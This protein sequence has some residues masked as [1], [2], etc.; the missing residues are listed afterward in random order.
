M[1]MSRKKEPT[2][3]TK[4]GERRLIGEMLPIREVSQAGAAEKG[5]GTGRINN[6]HRWWATR[7]TNVSRITA[8]AALVRPPL[9]SHENVIHDMYDY[10]KSTD[11]TKPAIRNRVRSRIQKV[12]GDHTPKVL[13][14]FGGSGALPFAAAW[15]GCESHSM[16]YNPVAVFI[17]KCALEYPAKYGKRLIKDVQD[18][19]QAIRQE[20]QESVGEFYPDSEMDDGLTYECYGYRWCRTI[21][22]VCGAIIPLVKSYMLSENSNAC[23]YPKIDGQAVS[24]DVVGGPY[25]PI[26]DG[27]YPKKGSIGGNVVKCPACGHTYTNLEMLTMFNN[28]KDGEQMLVAVYTHPK[29]RGRFYAKVDAGDRALYDRCAAELEKLREEFRTEYGIDPVPSDIIPTPDGREY[30]P[31]GP[32]WHV[33]EVVAHGYTRWEH[34]FNMRQLTCLVSMLGILRRAEERLISQHGEEYGC[35]IMSYMAL[36]LNRAV[37]RYCRLA[38]WRADSGRIVDCFASQSLKPT[39]D[40][41]EAVPHHIWQQSME[42]VLDGVV[43]AL[44]AADDSTYVVQRASATSLP[45]ENEHFDAV[46]TDPPYYDSMHYSKSSDFFYVWLRRTVGHMP[47]YKGLFRGVASPDK[48]EAVQTTGDVRN[49]DRTSSLLRD[50][51]GYQDLMTKS[52]REMYR[53]LKYDGVLTLVYAHKS[54]DG[55]ETLIQAMLDA[56]FT[57]TA[58]WPIDTESRGRINAHDT[59][60]LASSIYMVGRKWQKKPKAY[61]RDVLD[62]LRS[63]VCGRLDQFMEAGVSGADFYIAAIGVSCEVYG[64]YESVVRDDGSG[65][66][67]IS[68]MLADIRGICSDHIVKTLTTGPAGDIDAMSKLYISWRWAYGDRPVHY[69]VARKLFTGVGLNI[70][71][72]TGTILKKSKQDMTMLDHLRREKDIR[73]KNTIDVL[74]RALQLWRDQKSDEVDE[75]LI[76]TGN[77]NNPRFSQTMQAI[78]EAGAAKSGAHPETAEVRDMA[79]FLSRV[80]SDVG[81][82]S[83]GRL[84]D[85]IQLPKSE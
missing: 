83:T 25:G 82:A 71:D 72:H 60:S 52:L 66:V 13:D 10:A 49:L 69:D 77:M 11:H 31:G 39:A 56:G 43:A 20:I 73:P 68:K 48:D 67:T 84:D 12:W 24:F 47:M 65:L 7:P 1:T 55:W 44:S 42:S 59:A 54:T 78:M 57:V 15:L 63:H 17:Q 51:D 16:D 30:N 37:E 45:Y 75:L 74:H 23:L 41:A 76:S 85:F 3:K 80:K 79:A 8:Y 64:K 19:A 38:R 62:E 32:R 28:G 61:Y 5:R 34:L 6:L 22:C 9:P 40:Y 21:P 46:C 2:A 14:P 58:A 70:D 36:I 4:A 50:K 35:A 53:V 26:P 27:F 33:T 29:K 18:T 81:K